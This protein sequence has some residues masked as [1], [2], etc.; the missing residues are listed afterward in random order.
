MSLDGALTAVPIT[1]VEPFDVGNPR[2]LFSPGIR[3]AA[4]EDQFVMTR[5]AQRFLVAVPE[6][7]TVPPLNVIVN[8]TALM[9]RQ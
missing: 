6:S 5:D 2:P 1:S 3:P 8:W 7:S 9:N 4:V